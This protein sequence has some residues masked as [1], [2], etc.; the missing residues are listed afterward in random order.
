MIIKTLIAALRLVIV[1]IAFAVQAFL[2]FDY[3]EQYGY[4]EGMQDTVLFLYRE[5]VKPQ[6]PAI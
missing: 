5:S 3:G 6:Q 4:R 1:I 2:V